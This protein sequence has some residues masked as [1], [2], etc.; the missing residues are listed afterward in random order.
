MKFSADMKAFRAALAIA[1]KIVPNKSPIPVALCVKLIT[2]DSRVTVSGTNFDLT[3]E[4]QVPA[5]VETEG[6]ACI[7]FA[8]LNAFCAAAK[9]DS[10]TIESDK[11][12][13]IVRA[14]KS[15]IA[16]AALDPREFP[17]YQPAEGDMVSV[18]GPTFC[19]A[20]RFCAEAA[21]T[22]ETRYY[23]QGPC[24]KEVAQGVDIWGTD[25]HSMHHA[26][27]PDLP[28]V[29]GGGILPS[30]AVGIICNMGEKA[31]DLQVMI[32]ERG[33]HSQA[34]TVRAWGKV[35]D[36]SFPD[37]Q[38]VID[39]FKDWDDVLAAGKDEIAHALSIAA[40]GADTTNKARSLIIRADAGTPAIVRGARGAAGI[41]SAG[42]AETETLAI[43]TILMAVSAE[44]ISRAV[45]AIPGQD[46]VLARSGDMA[47]RVRPSQES[48]VYSTEAI[49]MGIRATEAELAD[50]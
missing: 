38:R 22:D 7:N 12:Q 20:L 47:A 36:G 11:Q 23:L 37:M 43:G 35:I 48:A 1:G 10:L 24:L 13:A 40:C 49:V 30:E 31:S 3:F 39:G 4:M 32:S 17:N 46:I 42:R 28:A 34:G 16:I 26:R 9:T 44:L 25:G 2:N 5:E 45:N 29:G 8:T 21:S 41:V 50:A 33:W 27:I 19:T 18:D 15:R 14:G 6:V